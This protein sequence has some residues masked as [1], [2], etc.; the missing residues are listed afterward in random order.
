MN[1]ISI[2]AQPAFLSTN[3]DEKFVYTGK[4]PEKGYLK[5]VSSIIRADQMAKILK[6][7]LNPKEDFEKD[8]CIY[9]KP[10]P[11]PEGAYEFSGKSTY[12]DVV[13]GWNY[14]SV[15]KENP[16]LK[17]IVCSERDYISLA[18]TGLTNKIVVIPQQHCNFERQKRT[19]TEI[20]KIGIVGNHK[21]FSFLP[22]DLKTKLQ[23]RGLELVEFSQFFERQ[24]IIDFYKSIDIQIVWRPYS[25]KLANPLK[26][27]NAASF[28]IPTIALDEIYFKDMG[29][30][31]IGVRN[32]DHF[33]VELD[34][35][36]SSPL[37][38]EA[39]SKLCLQK[40]EPYHIQNIAKLYKDLK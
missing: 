39:Y 27:V 21:A 31:Y 34:R 22:P 16:K 37:V 29:N 8:I 9:V 14:V 2:F 5:R 11:N 20:K 36:V 32:L 1:Y 10:E 33:F 7:N 24:D 40:S 12:I 26:I 3:P 30:C 18:S 15:L 19:R 6:A 28:G 35:L 4:K 17:A 25:K 38:Y 23:E 13:D